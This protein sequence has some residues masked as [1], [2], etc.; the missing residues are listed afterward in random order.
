VKASSAK[1]VLKA[2]DERRVRYLVAGGIAVNAYGY[3]R[4]TNDIDFVIELAPENIAG[5]FAALNTLG[6]QPNVPITA[7]QFSSHEMRQQWVNEKEMRVIQF[8]S[9]QHRETPVDVFIDVPFDFEAELAAATWKQLQG[10]GAIPV[11]TLP[12]LVQLKRAA[13]R[14]QDRIDLENLRLLYPEHIS[15]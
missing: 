3:L 6:Y 1:A 2:L 9:D 7:E 15:Q 12:T 14:E 4:F 10:V 11:L 8:W 13:N 5:A